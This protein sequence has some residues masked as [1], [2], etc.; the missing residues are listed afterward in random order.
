VGS[1]G[2]Y[3][4]SKYG[5]TVGEGTYPNDWPLLNRWYDGFNVRTEF[6]MG[7]MVRETLVAGYFGRM[8]ASSR[9]PSVR[10]VADRVT[11]EAP[12][13]VRFDLEASD[14]DGDIR[15][16]FWS[17][18]DDSFSTQRQPV[19]TFPR[20]GAAYPVVV[21]VVDTAG[22]MAWDEVTI[23]CR[24]TAKEGVPTRPFEL[25]RHTLALFRFDGSLD[26]ATE[27]SRQLERVSARGPVA[28]AAYR[29][30][31]LGWMAD[32]RGACLVMDGDTQLQLDLPEA[33][34]TGDDAAGFSLEAMLYVDAFTG[35]G[36]PGNPLVFGVQQNWDS[37]FGWRQGTWDR[38]QA[39]AAAGGSG[40]LLASGAVAERF[41][42]GRWCHVRLVWREGGESAVWVDGQRWAAT[43]ESPLRI[44]RD[45]PFTL[46]VGP[47]SGYLD[48]LRVR[49]M[50]GDGGER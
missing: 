37:W 45:G 30:D 36:Y 42:R 10:L 8:P 32:P 48:A 27:A 22:A 7:P 1:H 26:D 40:E 46:T 50:P 17:F 11:G 35:W 19:H 28:S 33:T 12:L 25:D 6:T 23:V 47:F 20:E 2:F 38:S 15:Q 14:P 4:F 39:P 16:V 18:G 24:S 43:E 31:V 5:K 3:W 9:K 21:T 44:D 29:Q 34:L 49:R 13:T 41:P